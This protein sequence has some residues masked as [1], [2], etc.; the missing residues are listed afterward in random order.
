MIVTGADIGLKVRCNYNLQNRTVSNR[1][2]LS[3]KGGV[4]NAGAQNAV[5][6]TPNV[7]LRVTDRAGD[8]ISSATVGDPLA[9]RFEIMEERSPFEIFVRELIAMDGLDSSEILLIDSRGEFLHLST[10]VFVTY[11]PTLRLS[12]RLHDHGHNPG[13]EQLRAGA[14]GQL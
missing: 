13:G 8:D 2:D 14:A 4:S 6:N 1:E 10:I 11:R 7:S 5:V 3:V 12:H 9:L